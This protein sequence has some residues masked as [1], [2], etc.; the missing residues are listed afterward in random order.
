MSG[1]GLIL[2]WRANRS[3]E[4]HRENPRLK[5]LA[6]VQLAKARAKEAEKKAKRASKKKENQGRK[7]EKAG[8]NE[9]KHAEKEAKHTK[10]FRQNQEVVDEFKAKRQSS[11]KA[12]KQKTKAGLKLSASSLGTGS[13]PR[14]AGSVAV[15]GLASVAN[16]GDASF[17]WR[18]THVH[19]TPELTTEEIELRLAQARAELAA[20]EAKA[21]RAVAEAVE[22]EAKAIKAKADAELAQ[23]KLQQSAS[24]ET[25]ET[26]SLSSS[27]TED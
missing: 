9:V 22:A 19:N 18:Q 11:T 6:R 17:I 23:L 16:A 21:A 25:S 7:K 12:R 5:E 27:T 1:A 10:T 15:A 8:D 13:V 24:Y 26:W 4:K 2:G 14:V 3:V 20:A